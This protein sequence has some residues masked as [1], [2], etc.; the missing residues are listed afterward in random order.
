MRKLIQLAFALLSALSVAGISCTSKDSEPG[1]ING[2]PGDTSPADVIGTPGDGGKADGSR[3][4]QCSDCISTNCAAEYD[5]CGGSC[6]SIL[7]CADVC[8]YNCADAGTG[9]CNSPIGTFPSLT[10][11]LSHCYSGTDGGTAM[12]TLMKDC[13]KG[14]CKSACGL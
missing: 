14:A 12:A 3:I 10:D 13:L 5:A 6:E 2:D 9:A 8:W 1:G 4:N 7:E 11:C